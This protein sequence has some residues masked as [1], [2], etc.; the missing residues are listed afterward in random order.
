[1]VTLVQV[2]CIWKLQEIATKCS[3]IFIT[4]LIDPQYLCTIITI[5]LH[6]AIETLSKILPVPVLV[7][8][9]TDTRD[10]E[11]KE[12]R[13]IESNASSNW[14]RGRVRPRC[15]HAALTRIP[16]EIS[17]IWAEIRIS[18]A[19]LSERNIFVAVRISPSAHNAEQRATVRKI[20]Y[21][22]VGITCNGNA[23]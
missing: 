15:S 4:R 1:M 16:Y 14:K 19:C 12:K 20:R 6:H 3:T 10:N 21:A 5:T 11:R 22:I 18:I 17:A 8:P 13:S 9:P 7:A 23:V 2:S